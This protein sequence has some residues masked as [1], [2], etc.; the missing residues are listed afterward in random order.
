[1]R[2]QGG[3][4]IMK[5]ASLM[6]ASAFALMLAQPAAAEPDEDQLVIDGMIEIVTEAPAPAHLEGLDT[7]Y[8]GW[9]FRKDDTQSIQADDFDNPA[10]IFVDEARDVWNTAEG[11]ADKS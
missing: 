2:P 8:S 6:A 7:I 5:K 11:S 1:M 3:D 4:H 10:M 9:R